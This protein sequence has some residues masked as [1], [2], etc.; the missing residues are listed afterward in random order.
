MKVIEEAILLVG[1]LGT[2][3][4]SIVKDIPKPLADVRGKPFLWHL[5]N[6]LVQEDVKKII[7]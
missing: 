6:K 7:L 5:I 1:G 2:R 3:L 4:R